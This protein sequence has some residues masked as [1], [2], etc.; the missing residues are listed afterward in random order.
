MSYNAFNAEDLKVGDVVRLIWVKS[1]QHGATMRITKIN[2]KSFKAEELVGSY[3]GP[4]K[5]FP[6]GTTWNIH[7]LSNYVRVNYDECAEK[8]NWRL[9]ETQYP[10]H[11]DFSR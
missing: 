1:Y 11:Y 4:G 8:N 9:M 2:K 6:N 7:K 3:G 5:Y 10:D